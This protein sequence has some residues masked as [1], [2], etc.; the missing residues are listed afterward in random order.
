MLVAFKE[1]VDWNSEEHGDL[2]QFQMLI[3]RNCGKV[4]KFRAFLIRDSRPYFHWQISELR[5]RRGQWFCSPS[6]IQTY[7][8]ASYL[9]D[10]NWTRKV[11]GFILLLFLWPSENLAS[12]SFFILIFVIFLQKAL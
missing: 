9:S 7:N 2:I 4:G 10:I 6:N 11:T 5:V 8:D 1:T 12:L 3:L